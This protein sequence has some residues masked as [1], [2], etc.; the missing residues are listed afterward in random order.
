MET[1]FILYMIIIISKLHVRFTSNWDKEKTSAKQKQNYIHHSN[2]VKI[3]ANREGHSGLL[4]KCLLT[5]F[6]KKKKRKKKP[7]NY[8]PAFCIYWTLSYCVANLSLKQRL[9]WWTKCLHR[10]RRVEFSISKNIMIFFCY[11]FCFFLC[12]QNA[13][14]K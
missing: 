7:N 4:N 8:P 13:T 9:G 2:T 1:F 5:D 14:A 6:W 10:I 3:A 12:S 11:H